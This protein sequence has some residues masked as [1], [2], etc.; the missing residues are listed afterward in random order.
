MIL[1]SLIL[2]R[3]ALGLS[4]GVCGVGARSSGSGLTGCFR[5]YYCLML[6]Q[7]DLIL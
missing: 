4:H 3:L 7:I 6:T 2:A 1:H 5:K